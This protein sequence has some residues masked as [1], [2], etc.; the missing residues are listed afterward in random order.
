MGS[1]S[2]RRSDGRCRTAEGRAIDVART[3]GSNTIG[4]FE[5]VAVCKDHHFDHKQ[6]AVYFAYVIEIRH[7]AG[8]RMK[9]RYGITMPHEV[10]MKM[11]ERAHT[12]PIWYTP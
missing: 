11:Q 3:R 1:V 5:C 12:T 4:D 9:Q 6:R 2:R 10:T 8:P 7:R